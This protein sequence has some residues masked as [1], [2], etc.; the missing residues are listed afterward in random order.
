MIPDEVV[1]LNAIVSEFLESPELEKIRSFH[2]K[3]TIKNSLA[4]DLLNVKGGAVHL[5]KVAMNLI[6]NAAE[7]MPDG[8]TIFIETRNQYF[9][10]A[11]LAY[12]Q[13]EE[14]EYIIMEVADE[15][16]GISE[17]DQEK[18]FEPFYSKK[19]LGRSGTGLGMSV[20]WGTVKDHNGYIDLKSEMGKGTSISII[21]PASRETIEGRTDGP[22]IDV[23]K[24]NG[25]QVLVVDDLEDQRVIA[26]QIIESLGY[27]VASC[28]SGWEALTY[29]KSKKADLVI[30]DM[31]MQDDMDGLDTF[32]E[33]RKLNPL[34]KAII[35]SGFSETHRVHKMQELGAGEYLRKPYTIAQLGRAVSAAINGTQ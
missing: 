16:F 14:G 8:G 33:I 7:A 13:I 21:L 30:L 29:L 18:I 31:I 22:D 17:E 20:I 23:Y 26:S 27:E 9:D 10:Q 15:G 34:Q 35:A 4:N 2:P 32:I 6:V 19:K 28:S 11:T 1:N 25:E 24:G 5:A 12:D 3:V